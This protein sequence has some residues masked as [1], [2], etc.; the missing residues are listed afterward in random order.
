MQFALQ[1]VSAVGAQGILTIPAPGAGRRN[2]I[3]TIYANMAGDAAS[4]LQSVNVELVENAAIVL[5]Y[6]MVGIGGLS[7]NSQYITFPRPVI[8]GANLDTII[9]FNVGRANYQEILSVTGFIV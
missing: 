5:I 6:P 8:M 9:R 7:R 3:S 1:T 2:V 4:V